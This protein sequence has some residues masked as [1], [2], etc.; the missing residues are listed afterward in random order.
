LETPAPLLVP[1]E[2]IVR[3]EHLSICGSDLRVYDRVLPED[4]YP[5]PIG[6]P[7][8]E[9][10]GVVVES[11]EEG[12]KV[13]QRVIAVTNIGGLAEY[14][15]VPTDLIVTLPED[16]PANPAWVLCQPLGTVIHAVEQMGSLFGKR[17][18]V[19]GQGPI[20]LTFTQLVARMGARQVIVCDKHDYRLDQAKRL[21][22]T[23][24]INATREDIVAGVTEITGGALAD[25][26]VE[27]TGRPEALHQ[28]F[29]TLRMRG[30][31]VIF[32]LTHDE[33]VFPIDWRMICEKI[34][35]ILVTNSARAGDRVDCV[36]TAVDLVNQGRIDVSHLLTH[37][38]SW[39]ELARGFEI[40]SAKAEDSLKVVIDVI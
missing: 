28:L 13:G 10:L 2:V 18:L 31:A 26:A 1:G 14:L 30:M 40:Y 4:E 37:R 27:A 6:Q 15:S 25:I 3:M 34:P 38:L 5:R 23:H 19:I 35:N 7:C 22:A 20:G 16:A 33:D 36:R 32:G 12:I 24:T 17:V 8:H 11:R 9:C 21:G 29:E 39:K